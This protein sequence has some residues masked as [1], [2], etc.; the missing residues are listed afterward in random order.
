MEQT[1]AD[2]LAESLRTGKKDLDPARNGFTKVPNAL[3][4]YSGF[5]GNAVQLWAALAHWAWLH[6]Q[7][8][9]PKRKPSIEVLC[10][11]TGQGKRALLS[12]RRDL[13]DGRWLDVESGGGRRVRSAYSLRE[14]VA[15]R[16]SKSPDTVA[17]RTKV[18]VAQQRQV[19]KKKTAEAKTSGVSRDERR[20]PLKQRQ[21]PGS[22]GFSSSK[23]AGTLRQVP[24][25]HAP[26]QDDDLSDLSERLR[27]VFAGEVPA[28]ES[29]EGM[30]R[31]ILRSPRAWLVTEKERLFVEGHQANLLKR[32]GGGGARS[33]GE[34][35]FILDIFT[36]RIEPWLGNKEA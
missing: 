3:L 22:A 34:K 20:E 33:A 13:V 25:R 36:Q 6:A 5:G 19:V 1:L 35:K 12:A 15:R 16:D 31:E 14:T 17:Q 10:R 30:W 24:A 4:F 18:T 8:K 28:G 32:R 21:Q 29:T 26:A 9:K 27:R 23:T 7:V 11:W 2:P